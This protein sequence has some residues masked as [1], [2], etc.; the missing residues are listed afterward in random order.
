MHLMRPYKAITSHIRH[1]FHLGK[2]RNPPL[3]KNKETRV[4]LFFTKQSGK[5]TC[6][7]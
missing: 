4:L 2:S 5:K 3:H 1:L 7:F 6:L